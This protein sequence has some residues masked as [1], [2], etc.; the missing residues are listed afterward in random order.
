MLRA[1]FTGAAPL[2][3]LA[4]WVYKTHLRKCACYDTHVEIVEARAPWDEAAIQAELFWQV[5]TAL[6]ARKWMPKIEDVAEVGTL[7]EQGRRMWRLS[8]AEGGPPLWAVAFGV[9]V[10]HSLRSEGMRRGFVDSFLAVSADEWSEDRMQQ[11]LADVMGSVGL[12]CS[13]AQ[14]GGARSWALSGSS[15]RRVGE[16]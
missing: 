4:A 7:V 11:F 9:A 3:D 5:G 2:H 10:L 15:A 13:E 12:G 1:V 8:L 16:I 6:L 14:S